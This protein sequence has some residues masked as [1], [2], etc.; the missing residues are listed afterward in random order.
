MPPAISSNANMI[1]SNASLGLFGL[2]TLNMHMVW[3][4]FIGGKLE[5]RVRY[6]GGMVYNTFPISGGTLDSLSPFDEKI[7]ETREK[8][9]DSTLADLYDPITMPIDLKKAHEELDKAVEELYRTKSF[10]SDDERQEFLLEEYQKM[11]GTQ[12]IL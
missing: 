9:S 5:T 8:Y 12:T 3:L 11:I 10:E 4:R 1:V 6:S 7:L 2:L